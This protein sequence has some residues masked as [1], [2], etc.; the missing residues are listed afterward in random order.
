MF[1]WAIKHHSIFIRIVIGA[2]SLALKSWD[3]S[4]P[5]LY[6]ES[7]EALI[8]QQD[9]KQPKALKTSVWE[10]CTGETKHVREGR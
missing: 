5:K 6:F 4:V 9:H 1:V 8:V 2:V 7:R 10:R 3:S